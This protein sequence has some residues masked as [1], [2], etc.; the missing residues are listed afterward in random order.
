MIII[1]FFFLL[2]PGGY[3]DSLLESTPFWL[4]DVQLFTGQTHLNIL[5]APIQQLWQAQFAALEFT[6]QKNGVRDEIIGFGRSGYPYVCPVLSI[7]C[8]VLYLC[9]NNAHPHSP[10]AHLTNIPSR[11]TASSMTKV[12]RDCVT[13][14]GVDLGFLHVGRA[15]VERSMSWICL[16]AI[17]TTSLSDCTCCIK[18][19][20]S[21][22]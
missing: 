14:L 13:Y 4:V 17:A 3:T 1:S 20:E 19:L 16:S 8:C 10:L 9:S 11:G 5:E 6:D 21:G 15:R 22:F 12:L 18:Y 2:H 7:I